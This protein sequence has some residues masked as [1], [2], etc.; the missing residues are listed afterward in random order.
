[1][2]RSC[3]PR[4]PNPMNDTVS[5]D[6]KL[7]P[8]VRSALGRLGDDTFAGIVR[9]AEFPVPFLRA[10]FRAYLAATKPPLADV[11]VKAVHAANE[12]EK[13]AGWTLSLGYLDSVRN[14]V[15]H[16]TGYDA[17]IEFVEACLLIGAR[18]LASPP[19]PGRG[20]GFVLGSPEYRDYINRHGRE[21]DAAFPAARAYDRAAREKHGQFATLNFPDEVLP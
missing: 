2:D 17:T 12:E 7:D 13:A 21:P 4:K 14:Y 3:H 20:E 9:T 8:A 16:H 1:M 15:A 18:E 10:V 11:T 19:M 6:V 5:E